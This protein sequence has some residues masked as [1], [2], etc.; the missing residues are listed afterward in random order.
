MQEKTQRTIAHVDLDAFYASVEQ[1]DQPEYR[2]QPVIVG[3]LGPRG[4]VSTASYEARRYGVHSAMPMAQ[5]RRLCP[6]AVYLPPRMARYRQASQ[7]V[8]AIFHRY[9]PLVEGLSLD[10]AFL[11]ISASLRLFGGA[12][13]IAE[14][15]HQAIRAETGLSAAVGVAP[16]KFLAKLTSELAKP[17]G[18]RHVALAQVQRLLDP[19]PV[20]R[21]W[22]V[23]AR[24]EEQLHRAG[25]LTI[26]Q[27]RC[28]PLAE[29]RRV[30]GNQ[31]EHYQR[32]CA[33][34]DERP[35]VADAAARSISN[36]ETFATN[37]GER[38]HLLAVLQGQ[39][40][41][42]ARRLRQAGLTARC[43]N[44]KLR[45]GQF[46]TVTRSKTLSR[47]TAETKLI[48]AQARA[49]FD[50]WW[51]NEGGKPLRLLGMGVSS[52]DT[53]VAD[54]ESLLTEAPALDR[55]LDDIQRRFGGNGVRFGRSLMKKGS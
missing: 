22:G 33:G 21:L 49:M 46:R 50:T 18:V 35:V 14:G 32:L 29:L 20:R 23:G 42:V 39:A 54:E 27:V 53:A 31:A 16:N 43:I 52:L 9:T 1:L 17:G 37:V 38:E 19:L 55:A 45:D 5:A 47:P 6:R 15:I 26:G 34:L 36:E 30:L 41:L 24:T 10:E 51:R 25:L 13:A 44:L 2:G 8:F 7:Q 3:G 11:D 40:E 28:C 48:Y 4:V 12:E